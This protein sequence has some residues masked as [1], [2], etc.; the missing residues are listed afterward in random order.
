MSNVSFSTVELAVRSGDNVE[1]IDLISCYIQLGL[2]QAKSMKTLQKTKGTYLR[3]YHTLLETMC[4]SCLSVKWRACTLE[5]IKQIMPI[6]LEVCQKQEFQQIRTEVNTFGAY[7]LHTH[8]THK[9][10]V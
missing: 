2:E 7:F 10:Q 8:A 4:D 6:L 9:S 3:M 5:Y 1:N